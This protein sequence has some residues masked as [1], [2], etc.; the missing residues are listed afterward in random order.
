MYATL[1]TEQINKLADT[2]LDTAALYIQDAL[3][4]SDGDIAG[5]FF[6]DNYVRDLLADYIRAE[7]PRAR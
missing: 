7:L 5:I 3:G 1:N 4:I 6:A 2:A